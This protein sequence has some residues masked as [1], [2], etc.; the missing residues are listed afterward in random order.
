MTF[1]RSRNP[2][3]RNSS[4]S[5]VGLQELEPSGFLAFGAPYLLHDAVVST[6]PAGRLL[7]PGR[8]PGPLRVIARCAQ[9]RPGLQDVG[10]SVRA[11]RWRPLR[12]SR[13]TPRHASPRAEGRAARVR[14]GVDLPLPGVPNARTSRSTSASFDRNMN[15]FA[16]VN[17]TIRALGTAARR[18]C[19]HRVYRARVA[20]YS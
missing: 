13:S 17:S 11:L 12:K 5:G 16:P 6:A 1:S 18:S 20:A 10:R 19:C 2:V 7:P 8:V 9:R 14:P 3:R 15:R 4:L